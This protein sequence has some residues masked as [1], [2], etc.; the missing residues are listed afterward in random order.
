MK[1]LKSFILSVATLTVMTLG[2][3]VTTAGAVP[4]TMYFTYGSYGGGSATASGYVEF[5]GSGDYFKNPTGMT[6]ESDH[7]YIVNGSSAAILGLSITVAGAGSG[8]GTFSMADFDYVTWYTNGTTL[9]MAQNLIGQQVTD[10]AFYGIFNFGDLSA[11]P[12]AGDFGL[13]G[14]IDSDAPTFYDYF[15]LQTMGGSGD[16]MQLTYLGPTNPVPE[17]ATFLLLGSGLAGIV[18]LRR[19]YGFCR[20]ARPTKPS[21]V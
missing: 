12:L 17:P 9:D 14:N 20:P 2:I 13:I 10:D 21:A 6:G 15:I 8:N 16:L 7:Y 4:Y 3:L 11:G 19:R 5:E 1:K 18:V